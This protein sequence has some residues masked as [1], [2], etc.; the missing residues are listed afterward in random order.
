MTPGPHRSTNIYW[1]VNAR[2][3]SDLS[4]GTETLKFNISYDGDYVVVPNGFEMFT[5]A[6]YRSLSC[7]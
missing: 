1:T 6:L 5:M 3:D 7:S 2:K 4:A